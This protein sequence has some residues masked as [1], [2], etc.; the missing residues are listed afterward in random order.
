MDVS[1]LGRLSVVIGEHA[2]AVFSANDLSL[3]AEHG[4]IGFENT[5]IDWLPPKSGKQHPYSSRA[6]KQV[7]RNP[8][9]VF[10]N[11]E[12]LDARFSIEWV[13]SLRIDNR[14]LVRH[15]PVRTLGSV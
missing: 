3:F 8:E 5:P 10:R 14:G 7:F 2:V 4:V 12:H 6:Y 1:V 15:V 11:A 9:R 13:G